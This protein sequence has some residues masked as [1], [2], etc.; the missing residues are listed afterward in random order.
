MIY[1]GVLFSAVHVFLIEVELIY[2]VVFISV[3]QQNG[4]VIHIYAFFFSLFSITVYHRILRIVPR[5]T[6]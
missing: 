2:S 5:V 3:I 4:S 1:N 6:Q